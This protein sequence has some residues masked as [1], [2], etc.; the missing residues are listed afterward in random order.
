[1][2][3]KDEEHKLFV[4]ECCS[5]AKND[6]VYHLSL[7]YTLGI[8]DSCQKNIDSL[9]DWKEHI[10]KLPSGDKYGWI[11]GTDRRIIRL[12]YNL[13]NNGCP[14]AYEIEDNDEKLKETMEY[15]PTNIFDYMDSELMEYCF[16]G[17][18][19]RYNRL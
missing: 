17:I 1:M 19:I 6:D 7:F 14:T 15:I 18:R 5:K 10:I 4:A 2:K 16:E 9:Y 3:F 12:A 8:S 11:T 13:F